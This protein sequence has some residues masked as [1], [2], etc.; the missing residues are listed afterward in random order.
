MGDFGGNASKNLAVDIGYEPFAIDLI[1]RRIKG[2][3]DAP[4]H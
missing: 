2:F 3:H 1:D 4:Q